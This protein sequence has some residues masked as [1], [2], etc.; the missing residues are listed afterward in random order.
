MGTISAMKKGVV[1]MFQI[2]V[3]L[4]GSEIRG[5]SFATETEAYAAVT[6]YNTIADCN[7]FPAKAYYE[8]V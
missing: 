3:S 1:K 6:E 4:W 2:V 7:G 8:Y 5:K